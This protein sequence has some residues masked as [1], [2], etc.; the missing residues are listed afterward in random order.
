MAAKKIFT[1]NFNGLM[2]IFRWP[3]NAFV[4]DGLEGEG[5]GSFV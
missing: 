2:L 4:T 5:R 1:C 3:D